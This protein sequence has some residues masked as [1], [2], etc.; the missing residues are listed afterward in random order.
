M[1]DPYSTLREFVRIQREELSADESNYFAAV[2]GDTL[3][4]LEYLTVVLERYNESNAPY[5]KDFREM[6]ERNKQEPSGVSRQM[7][8]AEVE[9]MN[10]RGQAQRQLQLEIETFFLF[11]NI[12]LDRIAA[13]TEYY[14]GR[15][16]RQWRSFDAMRQ[17]L[18]EYAKNRGLSEPAELVDLVAWLADN[19]AT[20]RH[21]L[22][23][24]KHDR[25]Y[26]VRVHFGMGIDASDE[27]FLTPGLLYPKEGEA[28]DM[29]FERPRVVY[30]QLGKFIAVWTK[31]LDENKTR[32]VLEPPP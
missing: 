11:A 32:R 9:E 28:L 10:R 14:F 31:Y 15:G 20:M 25:D 27:T 30:E 19:V 2:F 6:V 17:F 22:Q 3:Q 29:K 24:H 7:T 21:E 23:V 16:K 12:L 13:A 5:V 18:T 4:Y 26:T 8:D 1:A